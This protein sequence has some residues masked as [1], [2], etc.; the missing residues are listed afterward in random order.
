MNFPGEDFAS[1]HGYALHSHNTER[2]HINYV[3][4]PDPRFPIHLDRLPSGEWTLTKIVGMVI[5]KIGPFSL[6]NKNFEM[7]ERQIYEITSVPKTLEDKTKEALE[8]LQ[9]IGFEIETN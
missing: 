9:S 7:F 1:E 8:F 6:P 3:K 2:T 5:C 4:A